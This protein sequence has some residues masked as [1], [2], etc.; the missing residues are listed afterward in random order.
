MWD[1]SSSCDPELAYLVRMV[2]KGQTTPEQAAAAL[3]ITA[4]DLRMFLSACPQ[5]QLQEV[6]TGR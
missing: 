1:D 2:L 4:E 5:P 3:G 6:R